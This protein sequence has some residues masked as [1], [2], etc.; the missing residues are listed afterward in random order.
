MS[1]N[2]SKTVT[3]A[4]IKKY[5][6]RRYT[7]D[8]VEKIVKAF[9]IPSTPITYKEYC[10]LINNFLNADDVKVKRKL[11][12][13]IMDTNGDGYIC[14]TDLHGMIMMSHEHDYSLID[15][16]FVVA[17]KFRDLTNKPR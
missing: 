9:K 3:R 1:K 16:I 5:I 14:L 4:Q 7:R 11:A 15:D 2:K 6:E 13:S 8:A 12:F 10:E 17:K